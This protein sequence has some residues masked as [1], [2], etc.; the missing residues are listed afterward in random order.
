MKQKRKGDRENQEGKKKIGKENEQ[1]S[2]NI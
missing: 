2:K 1:E